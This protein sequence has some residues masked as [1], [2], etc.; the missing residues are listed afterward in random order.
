MLKNNERSRNV[1]ENKEKE[2]NLTGVKSDISYKKSD[3]FAK[4]TRI[5]HES[6]AFL[7]QFESW[8]TNR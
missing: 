5:S 4:P 6:W 8:G 7:S 2:D 3:I 1:Y